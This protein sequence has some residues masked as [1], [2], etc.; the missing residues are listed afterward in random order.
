MKRD[1]WRRGGGRPS[2]D[3]ETCFQLVVS[4]TF[5]TLIAV[6]LEPTHQDAGASAG[7]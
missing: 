6:G 7:G 2:R 1:A 5:D 3:S 4:H